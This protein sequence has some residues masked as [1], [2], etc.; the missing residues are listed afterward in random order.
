MIAAVNIARKAEIEAS[1]MKVLCENIYLQWTYKDKRRLIER[2]MRK[3]VLL[4]NRI[5]M[6]ILLLFTTI[7]VNLMFAGIDSYHYPLKVCIEAPNR[8]T[9]L[10]LGALNK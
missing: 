9:S 3:E 8:K 4:E 5:D 1:Y 6:P 10:L 7:I 2:K